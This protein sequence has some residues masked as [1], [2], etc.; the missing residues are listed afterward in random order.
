[1]QLA[2]AIA[3]DGQQGDH[4]RPGFAPVEAPPGFLQDLVDE[5]GA[6]FDQAAMS[7]GLPESA[8]ST[9]QGVSFH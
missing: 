8:S 3:A 5:P 1:M 4:R 6:V 2:A 7:N 9:S